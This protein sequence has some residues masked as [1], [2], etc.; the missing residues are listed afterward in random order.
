MRRA[1]PMISCVQSQTF[2]HLL[3][4]TIMLW[5]AGGV[6]GLVMLCFCVLLHL[7]SD[8]PEVFNSS[9]RSAIARLQQT[10]AR[11]LAIPMLLCSADLATST[12]CNQIVSIVSPSGFQP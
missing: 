4:W 6:T 5:A 8:Q 10:Y 11:R 3:P 2:M 12:F 7:R 9:S 1:A